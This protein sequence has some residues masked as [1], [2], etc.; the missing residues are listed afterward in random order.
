MSR[1]IQMVWIPFVKFGIVLLERLTFERR[2]A[3]HLKSV[4]STEA[5]VVLDVGA[6]TGQTILL[7][8]KHFNRPTVHSFEANPALVRILKNKN[9]QDVTIHGFGLSSKNGTMPFH[10]NALDLTSSFEA[11]DGLSAYEKMKARVLGVQL[12]Q[13]VQEVITLPVRKLADVLNEIGLERIDFLKIDV[14][15]HEYQ[16]LQG[17]FYG[18]KKL[19]ITRV[20]L[21]S[22]S[23]VTFRTQDQLQIEKLLGDEGYG[24]EVRFKHAFG[25]FEDVIYKLQS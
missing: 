15:G 7:W 6:N 17:L 24:E 12:N 20:Q 2:L 21:E 23:D 10:V 25:S 11:T 13:L 4:I 19:N 1:I 3:K 9:F 16:V 5:P 14:E 22:H 8:K 18:S